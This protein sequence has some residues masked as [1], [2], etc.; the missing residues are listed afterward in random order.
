[1][2]VLHWLARYLSRY[3]M[4]GLPDHPSQSRQCGNGDIGMRT[5]VLLGAHGLQLKGKYPIFVSCGKTR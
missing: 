4:T 5:L 2:A 3:V 1:M